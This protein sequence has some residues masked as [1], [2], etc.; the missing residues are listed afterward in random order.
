MLNDCRVCGCNINDYAGKLKLVS[1][2]DEPNRD[3]IDLI[4]AGFNY[5][6]DC[7][8]MLYQECPNKDCNGVLASN[9]DDECPLCKGDIVFCEKCGKVNLDS[10]FRCSDCNKSLRSISRVYLSNDSNYRR[11]RMS[12]SQELENIDIPQQC[13]R[14]EGA[15]S[16]SAIGDNFIYFMT[17]HKNDSVRL[18]S[19][20]IS[21]TLSEG[22]WSDIIYSPKIDVRLRDINSIEVFDCFIVT[23]CNERI[24]INSA[25]DLKIVACID[26][27][28]SHY[29]AV[30]FNDKLTV[31]LANS[32]AEQEIIIFDINDKQCG[33]KK[34]LDKADINKSFEI[35]AYPVI[36]DDC[37]YFAGYNGSIYKIDSDFKVQKIGVS[38]PDANGDKICISQIIV[39][40]TTWIYLIAHTK[41][42][43]FFLNSQNAND[44]QKSGDCQRL[45]YDKVSFDG[46]YFYLFVPNLNEQIDF[47]K[48]IA[49]YSDTF[50]LIDG[51]F[52]T[53]DPICDCC[54]AEFG[55]AS[56][57]IYMKKS[58]SPHQLKIQRIPLN[59]DVGLEPNSKLSSTDV[60]DVGEFLIYENILVICDH[61][62]NVIT[63]K[64]WTKPQKS[65]KRSFQ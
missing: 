20:D 54:I 31:M 3:T 57:L 1:F 40:D 53:G 55:G 35:T 34:T 44:F 4:E 42:K 58:K 25:Q 26:I 56:N 61:K 8:F 10:A 50:N 11:T 60:C 41:T 46:R 45:F 12:R 5:C 6:P 21:S 23:C 27:H 52:S 22:R 65:N 28:S 9:I 17:S 16:K 59:N 30:V 14:L 62:S 29:C 48:T 47:S 13:L 64:D 33:I 18:A 51:S 63:L 43:T 37:V 7:G 15:F 32:D 36:A 49:S 19:V 24:V 38:Y 39:S 2:V